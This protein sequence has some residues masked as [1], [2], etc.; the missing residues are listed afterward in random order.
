MGDHVVIDKDDEVV[1]VKM[2][3]RCLVV[4]TL[5]FHCREREVVVAL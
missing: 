2:A 5:S 3:E 4:G 1:D